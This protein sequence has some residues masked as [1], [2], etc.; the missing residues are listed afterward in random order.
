MQ[1]HFHPADLM[2]QSSHIC[3]FPFLMMMCY[4]QVQKMIDYNCCVHRRL[5]VND[6]AASVNYLNLLYYR[7]VR[8]VFC[9]K[10]LFRCDKF[11]GL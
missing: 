1:L 4:F 7:F 8:K 2:N 9:F 5:C 10:K 3:M 11:I 6:T